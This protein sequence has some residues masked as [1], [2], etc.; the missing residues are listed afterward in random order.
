MSC[1]GWGVGDKCKAKEGFAAFAPRL[2]RVVFIRDGEEGEITNIQNL[3]PH[4]HVVTVYWRELDVELEIPERELGKMEVVN[5]D[6]GYE[7]A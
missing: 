3:I 2:E 4:R 6:R 7:G 1:D 5:I